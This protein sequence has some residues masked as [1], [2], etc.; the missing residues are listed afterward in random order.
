MQREHTSSFTFAQGLVDL[1]STHFIAQYADGSADD[2]RTARMAQAYESARF[3]TSTRKAPLCL[4]AGDLNCSPESDEFLL[5]ATLTGFADAYSG[6]THAALHNGALAPHSP[7]NSGEPRRHISDATYGAPNNTY[8]AEDASGCCPAP[9]CDINS[10]L[11][12][13]LFHCPGSG[14]NAPSLVDMHR[15]P[16]SAG[17][18]G[19]STMWSV[20]S[21]GFE[22]EDEVVLPG[23]R[24]STLSDHTAVWA[25]FR[26]VADDAFPGTA[27]ASDQQPLRLPPAPSGGRHHH[28]QPSGQNSTPVA[29]GMQMA[30]HGTELFSYAPRNVTS[31][32]RKVLKAAL[33]TFRVSATNAAE[34]ARS[35]GRA[36]WIMAFLAVLVVLLVAADFMSMDE[37]G[38]VVT[39]EDSLLQFAAGA[40]TPW[41]VMMCL[42]L[43]HS[44]LIIAPRPRPMLVA[45]V[46]FGL[47]ML[48]AVGSSI[49]VA[50][51]L[52]LAGLVVGCCALG[53]VVSIISAHYLTAQKR[54]AFHM[55][56]VHI[57]VTLRHTDSTV[58]L[59]GGVE[60]SPQPNRG[61]R[62]NSSTNFL[63]V[64]PV[65][66]SGE[67]G[68]PEP[69]GPALRD[70]G[71]LAS[72][73]KQQV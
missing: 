32:Q 3:V 28:S 71:K 38:W 59:Q 64:D 72:V 45:I 56:S 29:I 69:K 21:S 22:C 52:A 73:P 60:L 49:W 17:C 53:A 37:R 63:L 2:Y 36:A 5:L 44:C 66:G 4:F 35:E 68:S 51:G 61:V 8:A 19:S 50:G 58:N 26:P 24:R 65:H 41:I 27:A 23:G 40:F 33:G 11:D 55:L 48:G 46:F 7:T 15:Q 10:R 62:A 9:Q 70:S 20:H 54:R 34:K 18:S 67:N 12:Y 43:S 1:Y 13:I 16:Y 57:Q 6:S 30:A 39:P 14:G 31:L 47:L 42:A 25:V